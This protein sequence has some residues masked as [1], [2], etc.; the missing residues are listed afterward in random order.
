MGGAY[1]VCAKLVKSFFRSARRAAMHGCTASMERIERL[2]V[3]RAALARM[4]APMRS[5][6][7]T[8]PRIV[9]GD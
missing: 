3:L 5:V 2:H 8:S 9:V 1:Q 7:Q 4:R 6:A